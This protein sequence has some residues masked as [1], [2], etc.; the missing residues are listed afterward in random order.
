VVFDPTGRFVLIA[1]KDL[2]RV[3]IFRFDASSGQRAPTE[4]CAYPK[5]PAVCVLNEL[6]SATTTFGWEDKNGLLTPT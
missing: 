4:A 6:D 5:L 3:F 1:D 2:D